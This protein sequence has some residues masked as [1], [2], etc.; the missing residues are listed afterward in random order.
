MYKQQLCN[1][2][3][4]KNLF[5]VEGAVVNVKRKSSVILDK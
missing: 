4:I 3:M 2:V 1:D 5:I